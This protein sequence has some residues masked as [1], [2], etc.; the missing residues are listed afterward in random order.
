MAA[1]FSGVL[2]NNHGSKIK[3]FACGALVLEMTKILSKMVLWTQKLLFLYREKNGG[4]RKEKKEREEKGIR[5]KK[6]F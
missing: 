4:E 5:R 2:N 1:C 3:K 6:R